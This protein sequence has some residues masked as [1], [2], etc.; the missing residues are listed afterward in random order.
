MPLGIGGQKVVAREVEAYAC[1]GVGIQ[2]EYRPF[3]GDGEG[4][5]DVEETVGIGTELY[6]FVG[7]EVDDGRVVFPRLVGQQF[8]DVA[9]Y[10]PAVLGHFRAHVEGLEDAVTVHATLRCHLYDLDSGRR[11]AAGDDDF[12][13]PF[14]S[15]VVVRRGKEEVVVLSFHGQP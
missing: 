1:A 6:P 11:T 2:E 3:V 15:A 8:L 14:H 12:G 10:V 9:S 7:F 5:F 13:H 4:Q